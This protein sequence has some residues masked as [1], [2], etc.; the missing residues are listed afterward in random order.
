MK[1][2]KM[3]M[4]I[5]VKIIK[6]IFFLISVFIITGCNVNYELS[7]NDGIFNENIYFYENQK[8]FI[9]ELSNQDNVDL[10]ADEMYKLEKNNNIFNKNFKYNDTYAGYEYVSTFNDNVTSLPTIANKC[11][12]NINITKNE[13]TLIIQTSNEFL[14]YDRFKYLNNINLKFKTNYKIIDSNADEINENELIFKI[15]E[16]VKNYKPIYIKLELKNV[17]KK[18]SNNIP[19]IFTIIIISIFISILAF[20]YIKRKK[21]NEF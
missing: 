10:L 7:Y 13:N 20:V 16:N 21:N 4:Q 9:D 18:Q 11:Y 19:L 1:T 15:N 17:I 2:L 8:T 5:N 14:C 3:K 6:Y 12:E